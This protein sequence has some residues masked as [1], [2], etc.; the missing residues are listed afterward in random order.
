MPNIRLTMTLPK[1]KIQARPQPDIVWPTMLPDDE[2]GLRCLQIEFFRGDTKDDPE[3]PGNWI[4]IPEWSGEL[5]EKGTYVFEDLVGPPQWI[6]WGSTV[7]PYYEEVHHYTYWG[8]EYKTNESVIAAEYGP[9]NAKRFERMPLEIVEERDND[10]DR[11][12]TLTGGANVRCELTRD[13]ETTKYETSP[14]LKLD[15]DEKGMWQHKINEDKEFTYKLL[16]PTITR[17]GLKVTEVGSKTMG[18]YFHQEDPAAG[19]PL[20]YAMDWLDTESLMYQP[21]DTADEEDFKVTAEPE[22]AA[23]A[24]SGKFIQLNRRRKIHLFWMPRRWAYHCHLTRAVTTDIAPVV[25]SVEHNC[26]CSYTPTPAEREYLQ[27]NGGRVAACN[28]EGYPSF[29][30]I[31]FTCDHGEC[32]TGCDQLRGERQVNLHISHIVHCEGSVEGVSWNDQYGYGTQTYGFSWNDSQGHCEAAD[33]DWIDLY[34]PGGFPYFVPTAFHARHRVTYYFEHTTA[35]HHEVTHHVGLWWDCPPLDFSLGEPQDSEENIVSRHYFEEDYTDTEFPVPEDEPRPDAI[36]RLIESGMAEQEANEILSGYN[37]IHIISASPWVH[38]GV[39]MDDDR[40]RNGSRRDLKVGSF[41]GDQENRVQPIWNRIQG[42][43]FF[44]THFQEHVGDSNLVTYFDLFGHPYNPFHRNLVSQPLHTSWWHSDHPYNR[45]VDDAIPYGVGLS[46]AVEGTLCAVIRYGHKVLYV[47]RK[48]DEEFTEHDVHVGG[49]EFDK[50]FV[51]FDAAEK[52]QM[53]EFEICFSGTGR[54]N[55]KILVTKAL[56]C[57]TPYHYG[58]RHEEDYRS[59]RYEGGDFA[60]VINTQDSGLV[61]C[62]DRYQYDF[63]INSG[64]GLYVLESPVY[65]MLSQNGTPSG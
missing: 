41:V 63:V 22:Y 21:F 49:P 4:V 25:T 53:N 28:A 20:S 17:V 65:V 19:S 12:W 54:K 51:S 13:K 42:T 33:F 60:Y 26:E 24:V 9:D 58:I 40:Y 50:P 11:R 1:K 18:H 62:S 37:S 44:Q 55:D 6:K 48:T 27:N 32:E 30:G 43:A 45:P 14:D 59:D 56:D 38:V 8:N 46:P 2:P 15:G 31:H 61:N 34:P 47:W 39:T 36:Q 57:Q 52:N 3:S 5:S 7:I 23:D 35:W 16:A 10:T 64:E 29:D